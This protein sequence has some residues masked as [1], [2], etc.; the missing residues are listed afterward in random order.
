M[1][2]DVEGKLW[3]E[4]ALPG[5]ELYTPL[6]VPLILSLLCPAYSL[7]PHVRRNKRKKLGLCQK[8]GYDLRASKDRCP[9]CGNEFE[10][11]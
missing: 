2:P 6:F 1:P 4:T 3:V 5:F 9:E 7:L 11:T 8:C 10:T